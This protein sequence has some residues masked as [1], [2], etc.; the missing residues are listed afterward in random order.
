VEQDEIPVLHW[1]VGVQVMFDTH[2]LHAPLLQTAGAAV[3]PHEVPFATFPPSVQVMVPDVHEV[4]PILQTFDSGQD[5]FDVQA[6]QMP[7]L[8][9][10]GAAVVPQF[11]P[12]GTLPDSTQAM[13]PVEQE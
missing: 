9:T 7:L 12:F 13:L 1:F 2:A 11:V 5:M 10:A 8:Q 6:P 3:V 4:T